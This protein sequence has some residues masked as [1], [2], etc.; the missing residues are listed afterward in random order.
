MEHATSVCF[1]PHDNRFIFNMNFF[2]IVKMEDENRRLEFN[3]RT[4]IAERAISLKQCEKQE[5]KI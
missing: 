5:N 2:D 1:N 3:A 4:E